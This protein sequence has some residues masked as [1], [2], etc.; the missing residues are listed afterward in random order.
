LLDAAEGFV[1][2]LIFVSMGRDMPVTKSQP[3]KEPDLE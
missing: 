1:A 2:W 3:Q